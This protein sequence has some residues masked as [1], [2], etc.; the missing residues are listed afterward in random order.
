MSENAKGTVLRIIGIFF[1]LMGFW[2]IVI[3]LVYFLF[4][5]ILGTTFSFGLNVLLFTGFMVFRM[6]YPKNVFI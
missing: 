4:C 2:F 5:L 1:T 3:S 6:F